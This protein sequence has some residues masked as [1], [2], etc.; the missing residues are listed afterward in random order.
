[1]GFILPHR[2]YEGAEVPQHSQ[3]LLGF[4]AVR[5]IDA[6]WRQFVYILSIPFGI[7]LYTYDILG[8]KKWR[9]LNPFWD[10]SSTLC[11]SK[12]EKE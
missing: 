3:S 7:Y 2:E 9:T 10:L 11:L 8:V 5:V 4:I 12:M 6:N 1:M